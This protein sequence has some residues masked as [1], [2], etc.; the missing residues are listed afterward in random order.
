[1]RK[2]DHFHWSWQQHVIDA[3]PTSVLAGT[4]YW[5]CARI[6]RFDG[7][8]LEDIFWFGGE[9]KFWTPE[10]AENKMVLEF[11]ANEDEIEPTRYPQ[12]YDE[13]DVVDLRHPNDS[14][15]T[16][17]IRKG[18]KRSRSVMIELVKRKIQ[19]EEHKKRWAEQELERLKDKVEEVVT[20][21]DNQLD[22]IWI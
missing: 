20:A 18:A 2:G 21:T 6:V 3:N 11:I 5:C 16:L 22:K 14:G 8:R 13:G 10:D 4:L 1:M 17:Y 12:Y 15:R 9:N 7:N 19:E